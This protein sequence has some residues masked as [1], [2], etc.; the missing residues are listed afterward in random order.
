MSV[1][2]EDIR[3]GGEVMVRW[4]IYTLAVLSALDAVT[5]YMLIAGGLGV[6][7]NPLFKFINYAPAA[8]FLVQALGFLI[9]VS[10]IKLFEVYA[11]KLPP[12][13]KAY[14]CKAAFFAFTAAA[15]WKAA[16]VVNNMLGIALGTTPLA[17]Y[18]FASGAQ[19]VRA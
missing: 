5:T 12:R 9:N 6:E 18:F 19:S 15:L 17:D 4:F 16:A 14:I 10:M 8:A 13:L 11:T 1:V 7:A 3:L 2:Q